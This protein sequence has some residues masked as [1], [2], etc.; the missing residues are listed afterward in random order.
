MKTSEENIRYHAHGISKV[1]LNELDFELTMN[2]DRIHS[3]F[4]FHVKRER[5]MAGTD[6]YESVVT[7][8]RDQRRSRCLVRPEEAIFQN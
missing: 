6:M 7:S 3:K 5:D 4:V 1:A 2:I 8:I